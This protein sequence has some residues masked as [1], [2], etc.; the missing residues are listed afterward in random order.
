MTFSIHC[1]WQCK[2]KMTSLLLFVLTLSS[3]VR[4]IFTYKHVI[5][6]HGVMSDPS[7]F[8]NLHTFIEKD[9]PGTNVTVIDAYN[10]YSSLDNLWSQANDILPIVT[11]V[12]QEN[13]GGVHLLCFS[14]GGLLCRAI[15]E[16]SGPRHNVDTFI[17][18]SSPQAGQYGDTQV[19]HI[20]F[21][22]YVKRSLYELFY[23]RIGQ[24]ISIGNYWND[25][26]HQQLYLEYCNFLPVINNQVVSNS[27]QAYK[28]SFAR[29]KN[30]VLIGGPDDDV[31][32]PWQSS[33]FATSDGND[34]IIPMKDQEWYKNDSFGLRTL[35][36]RG[37]VHTYTVPGH[38]HY[39]WHRNYTV[40][41]NYIAPWLT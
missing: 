30:L 39:D 33:H 38:K 15:I 41:T 23:S 28:S 27:S 5:F 22:Y 1:H 37:S 19:L 35:D 9:H 21:P 3:S 26:L 16:M 36:E 4:D 6:M 10:G 12:M 18:L 7:E 34:T 20:L 32:M 17:S 8:D 40:F 29:L 24:H 11:K 2:I 13:T 31:I 25:P 14:Q